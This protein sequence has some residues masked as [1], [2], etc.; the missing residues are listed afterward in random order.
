MTDERAQ[1]AVTNWDKRFLGLAEHVSSWSKDPRTKVG[2]VIVRP[3]R[4]VVSVGYNGFPRGMTDLPPRYEDKDEKY[5]RIV[6]AEMNAILH[7]TEKL[8]G[9]TLY[10][11]PFM[12]CDRCAVAVIQSGITRVVSP[13]CPEELLERWGESFKKSKEYYLEGRVAVTEL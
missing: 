6:H 4:T 13:R 11:W 2:A 12:T 1:K 10:T 8:E 5:S 9:Y 7:S 3:N